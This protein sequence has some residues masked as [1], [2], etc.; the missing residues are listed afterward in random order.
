[1][2][3]ITAVQFIAMRFE[4]HQ[5]LGERFKRRAAR[6][7][8]R[9]LGPLDEPARLDG[10]RRRAFRTMLPP[11]LSAVGFGRLD[12][13]QGRS[14]LRLA[15]FNRPF[16]QAFLEKPPGGLTE[17][18]TINPGPSPKTYTQFVLPGVEVAEVVSVERMSELSD[19]VALVI[20]SDALAVLA[21]PEPLP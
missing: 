13:G 12:V 18:W 11:R 15:G 16:V 7:A 4:P 8:Y 19:D 10:L 21:N 5:T 3:T 9:I 14:L 6:R 1:M 17:L 2:S 20:R